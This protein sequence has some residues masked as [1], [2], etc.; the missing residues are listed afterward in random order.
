MKNVYYLYRNHSFSIIMTLKKLPTKK[1]SDDLKY[2]FFRILVLK[3][4][5]ANLLI[6]EIVEG[7]KDGI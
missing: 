1:E 2:L 6:K 7:K 3:I 5:I 4:K